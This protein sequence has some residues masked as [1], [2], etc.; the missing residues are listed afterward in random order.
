MAAE[1]TPEH[2]ATLWNS[3]IRV[4]MRGSISGFISLLLMVVVHG[5][6]KTLF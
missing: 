1:A 4:E 6:E 2:G 5:A 3:A